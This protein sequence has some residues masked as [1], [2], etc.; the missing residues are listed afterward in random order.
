VNVA[1]LAAHRCPSVKYEPKDLLTSKGGMSPIPSISISKEYASSPCH[2]WARIP[3]FPGIAMSR[4]CVPTERHTAGT[5]LMHFGAPGAPFGTSCSYQYESQAHRRSRRAA[6]VRARGPPGAPS[7][8]VRW[9]GLRARGRSCSQCR[10]LRQR[11]LMEPTEPRDMR[12]E[13]R[14]TEAN[15]A[16]RVD[17][18][19]TAALSHPSRHRRTSG[20]GYA[21]QT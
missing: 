18:Q 16:D 12:A 20:L 13:Q 10:A 21:S 5:G 17:G 8:S 14:A 19:R 6:P 3:Q 15:A 11:G 2:R 9:E 1:A 7:A 4:R